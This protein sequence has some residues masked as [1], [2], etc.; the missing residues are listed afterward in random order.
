MKKSKFLFLSVIFALLIVSSCKKEDPVVES[1]ELVNYVESVIDVGSLNSLIT[2]EALKTKNTASQTSYIIDTRKAVDYNAGHIPN[3]VNVPE[4]TDLISHIETNESAI[5]SYEEIV[6]VCYSGQTAAF[7]TSLLRIAGYDNVKNMLFGMTAWHSD[8]DKWS[9]NVSTYYAQF[10]EST[11]NPKPEEGELP[12]I[13]TGFTDG[14]DIL[15]ARIDDTF[16]AGFG[17]YSISASMVTNNPD[18]YFIINYWPNDSYTNPGHIPGAYNY[19]PGQSLTL[20]TDLKTLPTD[21]TIV[22]YCYTGTGSAFLAA[23][24]GVLGYDAKSLKFGANS[25]FTGDLPKSNW[26]A[27]TMIKNYDYVTK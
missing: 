21:K 22:V 4:I 1:D 5:S 14:A 16:E 7:A 10:L 27:A 11:E 3:A 17:E 25:M 18:N 12:E 8:F 24:L 2:A 19:I 20:A 23:Y 15:D 6:L 26:N 9:G 13:N